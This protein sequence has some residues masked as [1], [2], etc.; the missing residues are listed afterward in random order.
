MKKSNSLAIFLVGVFV[1]GIFTSSALGEVY[2]PEK[3]W[4]SKWGA[5]DEKGSFNTI[6]PQKILS[7]YSI[8]AGAA[9]TTIR[10][11]IMPAVRV[12]ELRRRD[13]WSRKT[14]PCWAQTPGRWMRFP[15]KIPRAPLIS[16]ILWRQSTESG[17]LKTWITRR[18]HRWQRMVYMSFSGFLCPYPL[19]ERP[20]HR[21]MPSRSISG[22]I[23]WRM[24]PEFNPS[25]GDKS[26]IGDMGRMSPLHLQRQVLQESVITSS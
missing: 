22:V 12:S 7:S 18:W 11:P 1:L 6:T 14:F 9:T 23:Y 5:D 8:P 15:A 3:W 17:I 20:D 19:Q 16:T 13:I 21:V 4:P 25:N 24:I 10:R 26:S 2:W